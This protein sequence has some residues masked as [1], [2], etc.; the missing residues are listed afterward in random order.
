MERKETH[1]G[2]HRCRDPRPLLLAPTGVPLPSATRLDVDYAGAEANVAVGLA[3]LGHVAAFQGRLGD[4]VFGRRIA[5]ALRGEGVRTDGLSF[6]P[7][8]PTG[9]LVRD[10]VQGRPI[11]VCY[12]R[13]G[14]AASALGPAT[15]TSR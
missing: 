5:A 3:R 6:D 10:V 9:L 12:Y 2:R 1:A 4:D 7:D 11:T 13:S 8:R 14:S 15:W